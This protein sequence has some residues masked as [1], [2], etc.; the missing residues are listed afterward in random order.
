MNE[1]EMIRKKWKRL[2]TGGSG[3]DLKDPDIAANIRNM[4][5]EAASY[6][7]SMLHEKKRESL[8]KDL[9]EKNSAYVT[10]AYRRIRA[11]ALV[12]NMEGSVL[13]RKE[14]LKADIL[15]ALDW[16]SA[17]R[18]NGEYYK[19]WWDWQ[20][21]A[22]MAMNDGI[23]LMYEEMAAG[24]RAVCMER[25]A[26]Y[27]GDPGE[28]I[29]ANRSWKCRVY[30]LYGAITESAEHLERARDCFI[31]LCKYVSDDDGM[32]RDG[33]FIQ[34]HDHPY[35]MGYGINL[36][37]DMADFLYLLDGSP[38][39]VAMPQRQ[40]VYA[41]VQLA[42]EPFL[43]HGLA[44]DMV[45]GREMAR[46]FQQDDDAGRLA[47]GAIVRLAQTAPEQDV[48]VYGQILRRELKDDVL[49]RFYREASSPQ[50][51]A[52]TKKLLKDAEKAPERKQIL[53][54]VFP[55]MDR[56]VQ[57]GEGYAV[58][59]S[60][61]SSR[62]AN[63]E[64]D[65]K[66]ENIRGWHTGDGMVY[67][68]LTDDDQYHDHFWPTVDSFRLPGTTI[69][70][71]TPTKS[72]QRGKSGW[73]GGTT[74]NMRYGVCGMEYEPQ[75][76]SLR[77]RKSW[78]L[79][80]HEIVALGA[81]I[82]SMDHIPVETVVENRKLNGQKAC[83]LVVNGRPRNVKEGQV[84]KLEGVRYMHLDGG[85]S[86]AGIG[87]FFPKEITI[88]SI[89]ES[90]TDGWNSINKNPA[91]SCPPMQ[92]ER[93][94]TLWID[95]GKDPWG[96]GYA[97][98]LLP[99]MEEVQVREYAG[100]PDIE[101]LRNDEQVQAVR[102]KRLKLTGVNFWTRTGQSVAGIRCSQKASVLLQEEEGVLKVSISDPA[103]GDDRIR[104][105]IDSEAEACIS[106]DERIGIRALSPEIVLEA[107]MDGLRGKEIQ[108]IFRLK[109]HF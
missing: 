2:L 55:E 14:E 103:W 56:V 10:A 46:S 63:Y 84:E 48:A 95:H 90:R 29:G 98:V 22:P 80:D 86:G 88:S 83:R 1:Y 3:L 82:Y 66:E 13:Y 52:Q 109:Q 96:A 30:A 102:E 108:A 27:M 76:Y 62:T 16:M 61:Y 44:M 70:A 32:Y 72:D 47:L 28:D 92:T 35:N 25:L 43:Y 68:Y 50:L 49:L 106:G 36:L 45:R 12:W 99:G 107:D 101:I 53:C 5:E 24:Q 17:Y 60:M 18:Y 59:I 26:G 11:M 37:S 9:Q 39:E 105:T 6:W 71:R 89:R 77:V 81:G 7:E 97:Y 64:A 94:Q 41:W 87:Y 23:V 15:D 74:I 73:A 34:H 100:Q 65:I 21:G 8:W 78:F 31:S 57:H 75:E 104:L 38:W 85:K 20:I 40:N 79:F 51:I 91:Q 42:Y 54:R 19:D 58:G 33:S 93:Y 4:T 67:L 69:L